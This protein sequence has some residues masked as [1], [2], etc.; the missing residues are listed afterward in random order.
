M[1]QVRLYD[2]RWIY[3][4]GYL[5]VCQGNRIWGPKGR[6]SCFGGGVGRKNCFPANSCHSLPFR[7]VS[8]RMARGTGLGLARH[9]G[10]MLGMRYRAWQGGSVTG[11]SKCDCSGECASSFTAGRRRAG[12]SGAGMRP[13]RRRLCGA[14]CLPAPGRRGIPE[15]RAGRVPAGGGYIGWGRYV[16]CP[17]VV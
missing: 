13:R 8:P 7:F 12:V 3:G 6:Y 14:G 9:P 17:V 16:P 11:S 2:I 5:G 4:Y 15:R 1:I 10:I